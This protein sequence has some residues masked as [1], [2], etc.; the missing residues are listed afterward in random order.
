MRPPSLPAWPARSP[1]ALHFPYFFLPPFSSPSFFL[2][3]PHPNRFTGHFTTHRRPRKSAGSAEPIVSN[4]CGPCWK[5]FDSNAGG[6]R[7]GSGE[8]RRES[9][10]RAVGHLGRNCYVDGDVTSRSRGRG[11]C[12]YEVSCEPPDPI[13]RSVRCF[14]GQGCDGSA[15]L[16]YGGYLLLGLTHPLAESVCW[17]E[18]FAVVL[19]VRLATAWDESTKVVWNAAPRKKLYGSDLM[20]ACQWK[21]LEGKNFRLL[22]AFHD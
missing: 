22:A 21:G 2:S 10:C 6:G 14:M 18:A 16:Q 15:V 13:P 5:R 20:W 12:V 17:G 7:R 8:V 4:S 9:G 11:C 3:I 1:R 19:K